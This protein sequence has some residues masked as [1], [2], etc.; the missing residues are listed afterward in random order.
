MV[1][2]EGLLEA[3]SQRLF[4]PVWRDRRY[5]WINLMDSDG[6]L[7]GKRP[8]VGMSG[9]ASESPVELTIGVLIQ[10]EFTTSGTKPNPLGKAAISEA[11][12]GVWVDLKG[13]TRVRLDRAD[14]RF[15]LPEPASPA[16][17]AQFKTAS[18]NVLNAAET[19][20]DCEVL[21]VRK[22]INCDALSR[23]IKG[24]VRRWLKG[25]GR[26]MR[27]KAGHTRPHVR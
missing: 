27:V 14:I 5:R 1:Q 25:V 20:A 16:K 17:R 22:G 6:T 2:S 3:K 21:I 18:M 13:G 4:S 19:F 11:P 15:V 12:L 10:S 9:S 24:R 26:P 7:V 23:S 8:V